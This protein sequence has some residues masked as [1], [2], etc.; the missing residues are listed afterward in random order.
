MLFSPDKF[1][2]LTIHSSLFF[3]SLAFLSVEIP[4]PSFSFSI[5]FD[6]FPY[7][8]LISSIVLNQFLT[9]RLIREI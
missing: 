7:S 4:V 3:L 8:F 9:S 2:Y 1:L 5:S 6:F